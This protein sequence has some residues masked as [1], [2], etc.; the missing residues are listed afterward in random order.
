MAR[1]AKEMRAVEVDDQARALAPVPRSGATGSLEASWVAAGRKLTLA[2]EVTGSKGTIFVDFERQN[3]LQF[4]AAGQAKGRE[5]FKTILTG[6]DHPYY[7][8]FC[9]APGHHLGF[10]DLETLE[11]RALLDALS[12]G[13]KAMPDFREAWEVQRVV[14]GIV[15]SA[16]G[17]PLARHRRN[18]S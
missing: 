12:G 11:V 5:G 6:P 8:A 2:F 9:P 16:S 17:A 18:L 7:G 15:R 13:P 1:G 10:N 14:D 4:Y 3:E